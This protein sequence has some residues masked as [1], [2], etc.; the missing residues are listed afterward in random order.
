MSFKEF[1][2]SD[3]ITALQDFK[4]NSAE[5]VIKHWGSI[6]NFDMFIQKIKDDESELAKL[7]IQQFGSIEK[8]TEAMKHNLEH[9]SELMDTQLTEEVKEIGKQSDILYG[10]L[11]ADLSE[12]VS[13]SKIQSIVQEIWSFIQENSTN[14]SISC[15]KS[16]MNML[17][18]AYSNDYI[19]SMT[20]SKYGEGASDYIVKAF[21]YYSENNAS[22]NNQRQQ[23]LTR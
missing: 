13:S 4:N 22:E 19:K 1:D 14:V 17:I 5:D 23:E 8:Y 2:L 9:F 20:D 3:Y 10:R 6:E 15:S 11:T 16:H 21:R 7:A 12:D 18:N